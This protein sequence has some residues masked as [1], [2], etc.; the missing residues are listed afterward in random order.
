MKGY[1]FADS[2]NILNGWK[3]YLSRLLNVHRI[4][5]ARR[6]EIYTAEPLIPEPSP[7]EVEIA[8]EKLKMFT[9]PG[10]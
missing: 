6:V 7:V 2:H 3:N 8:I 1:L 5:D 9:S 4:I 10:T